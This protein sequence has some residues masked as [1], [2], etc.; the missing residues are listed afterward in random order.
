MRE[1]LDAAEKQKI[2]GNAAEPTDRMLFSEAVTTYR[3]K[4][5][6]STVRRNAKAYREAGLKLIL[7]FRSR[8]RIVQRSQGHPQKW[9]RTGG[10]DFTPQPNRIF[11]PEPNGGPQ[12]DRLLCAAIAILEVRFCRPPVPQ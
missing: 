9:Q 10:N 2:A 11:L 5:A 8:C 1:H 12:F 7:K 6:S 4:L 3:E